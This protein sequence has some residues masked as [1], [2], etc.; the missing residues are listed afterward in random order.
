MP[1]FTWLN[2]KDQHLYEMTKA[3]QAAI[4]M[5]SRRHVAFTEADVIIYEHLAK[6]RP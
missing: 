5:M 1:S 4:A 3:V 2:G 6:T